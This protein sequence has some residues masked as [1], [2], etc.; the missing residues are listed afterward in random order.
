MIQGRYTKWP[1]HQQSIP[2]DI[3]KPVG[4]ENRIHRTTDQ[5]NPIQVFRLACNDLLAQTGTLILIPGLPHL[6]PD[7]P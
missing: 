7:L 1:A 5:A 6:L 3:V 4:H 2:G